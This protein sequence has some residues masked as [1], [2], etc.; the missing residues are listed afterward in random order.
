[1]TLNQLM[2]R[3]I[4]RDGRRKIERVDFSIHDWHGIGRNKYMVKITLAGKGNRY[5]YYAVPMDSIMVA[6]ETPDDLA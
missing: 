3:R 4:W 2:N 5:V 6:Q 1:M